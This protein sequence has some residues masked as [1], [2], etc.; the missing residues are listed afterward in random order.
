MSVDLPGQN[1]SSIAAALNFCGKIMMGTIGDPNF[2]KLLFEATGS[3]AMHGFR[4]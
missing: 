3:M 2:D 4:A 1:H